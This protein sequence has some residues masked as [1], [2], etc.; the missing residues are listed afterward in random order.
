MVSVVSKS[1]FLEEIAKVGRRHF[2][3]CQAIDPQGFRKETDYL[4]GKGLLL[5]RRAGLPQG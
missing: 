1:A 4:Y 2:A 3:K 5:L